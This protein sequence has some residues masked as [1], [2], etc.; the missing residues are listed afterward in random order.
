MND[1]LA[2]EIKVITR[3]ANESI[4][5]SKLKYPYLDSYEKLN[6]VIIEKAKNGE[7]SIIFDF[8]DNKEDFTKSLEEIKK[9][10]NRIYLST[11]G[12]QA[13]HDVYD[14]PH[15]LI[16]RGFNVE[17]RKSLRQHGYNSKAYYISW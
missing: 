14:F 1:I 6:K 16:S 13:I 9:N 4:S 3:Q 8:I 17:I 5:Y 12:G 2:S 11:D 7:N 10:N 15:Y